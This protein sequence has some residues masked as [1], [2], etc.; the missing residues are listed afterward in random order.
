MALSGWASR[1]CRRFGMSE[2]Q[3][4]RQRQHAEALAEVVAAVEENGRQL[5]AK[6]AAHTMAMRRREEREAEA[7]L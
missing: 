2:D 1:L 5:K 4:E 7:R 6:E 3:Q